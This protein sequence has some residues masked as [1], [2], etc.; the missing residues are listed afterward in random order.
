M[1]NI[2]PGG[3]G[4]PQVYQLTGGGSYCTGMTPT[5]IDITLQNSQTDV[6]YQLYNGP[7]PVGSSIP[8]TGNA[9][10]WENMLGGLYMA[11]ATNSWGTVNMEGTIIITELQLPELSCPPDNSVSINTTPFELTGATPEDG[12]Y[13]GTGVADGFFYPNTAGIGN[14]QIVYTYSDENNCTNTCTF[15]ITVT[16]AYLPGDANGDGVVNILDPVTISNF[17]MGNNPQPF[18]FEAADV[19]NDGIINIQDFVLTVNIIMGVG[20]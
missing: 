19:N 12:V 8:G 9:I 3:S 2:T 7:N 6:N 16:S 10:V 14:H 1:L 11:N 18:I 13:S 4:L 15:I 5:G 20:K 17:I